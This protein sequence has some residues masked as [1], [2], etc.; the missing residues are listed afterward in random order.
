MITTISIIALFAVVVLF[1]GILK[2]R[3]QESRDNTEN[4]LLNAFNRLVFANKAVI[5]YYEI[6]GNRIIALDKRNF[7]LIFVTDYNGIQEICVPLKEISTV[8]VFIDENDDGTICTIN[9]A[10]HNNRNK[11]LYSINFFQDVR[12]SHTA[13]P[14]LAR[15][16]LRWKHKI[17]Q[18][19][20]IAFQIKE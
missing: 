14:N 15:R 9:L 17:G 7:K 1:L 6:I 13:L 12:D 5:D 18:Y 2:N 19:I 4:N 16:A 8:E 10:L 20:S 11:L 3:K